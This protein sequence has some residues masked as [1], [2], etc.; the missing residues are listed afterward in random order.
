[1]LAVFAAMAMMPAALP[2]AAAETAAPAAVSAGVQ[3]FEFE[4]FHAHYELGLDDDGHA[5]ARVT[6]TIVAV[7]PDFDQNR[8]IIRAIPA[9]YRDAS[10]RLMVIDV[11]DEH[12]EWVYWEDWEEGGF[13]MLALGDDE[14]VHGRTTYVIEYRIHDVIE[15]FPDAELDEFYWDVNGTGWAQPF[16]EVSASIALSPELAAATT[17]ATACFAGYFGDIDVCTLTGAGGE[18]S[19]AVS[20]LRPYQTMTVVVA[21]EGGTV[22]QPVH[23]RDSPLVRIVPLLLLGLM[24]LLAIA[25]FLVR[26]LQWADARS[27]RP[28]IAQYQAP[29]GLDLYEA[30]DLVGNP[31]AALPAQLVELAVD[32]RLR[33]IDA[34]PDAGEA[35]RF[36]VEYGSDKDLTDPALKVM[37]S[38]FGKGAKP[39][40]RF[41]LGRLGAARSADLHGVG[42][43]AAKRV[44][45]R[46]LR[47]TPGEQGL[48]RVLKHASFW[49]LVAFVPLW[50]WAD[51]NEAFG[52]ALVWSIVGSIA[53]FVVIRVLL[54][55]RKALTQEGAEHYHHL[56][57][58]REYLLL[59]EED[60]I[61]MLQGPDTAERDAEA[62]LRIYER[63]LPYAILWGVEKR[64]IEHLQAL[65]PQTW[66]EGA[67][68]DASTLRVFE[69]TAAASARPL[70]VYASSSSGGSS[71]SSSGSSSSFSGSS[72]GGFSGGGGG[73]GGGGGR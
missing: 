51:A 45:R 46:G 21:F 43:A 58:I 61:R 56:R 6:E 42:V 73:G 30:A 4:S 7:F 67:V 1:M 62:V 66:Y 10:L 16:A 9:E 63:L 38:I 8:G 70:V 68:L 27:P 57:G 5:V 2:A 69:R 44:L 17:G 20:D 3:D 14:Y 52:P 29:E 39:G 54:R 15:H 19:A 72:G 49:L 13:V 31:R 53:V 64:W 36:A 47:A 26:R 18:Y 48:A 60:R 41:T 59:A 40:R 23:P 22:V 37:R 33:I 55:E 25:A 35:Y 71:W 50:F 12:G 28:L 11:T 32:G 24:A 65:A 34:N